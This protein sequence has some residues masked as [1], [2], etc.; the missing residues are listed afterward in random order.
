MKG[1]SRPQICF[2]LEERS[3]KAVHAGR[4]F[5]TVF[6]CK[7]FSVC[8]SSCSNGQNAI[9]PPMESVSVHLWILYTVR[10]TLMTLVCI[11]KNKNMQEIVLS[12]Q[13]KTLF[14]LF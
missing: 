5:V 1:A 3:S 11:R 4:V 6:F 7:L 8:N 2:K 13:Q 12:E 10:R 9:H 14:S